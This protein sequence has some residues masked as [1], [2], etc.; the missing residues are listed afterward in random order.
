MFNLYPSDSDLIEFL[1]GK[2]NRSSYIKE[3]IRK[4]MSNSK[5]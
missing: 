5:N 4:D 2:E 1:E 3:L